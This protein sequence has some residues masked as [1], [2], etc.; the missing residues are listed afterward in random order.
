IDGRVVAR[1]G[2][3]VCTLDGGVEFTSAIKK[4]TLEQSGP[5]RATVK[6]EGVHK[7]TS[8]EWLPFVV[9]LYFYSGLENVRLVHTIV[10][11]GDHEKDFIRGLGVAFAV[12][13]R[14]QVHNRHVRFSGEGDG[15]WS[16]PVQPAIGRRPLSQSAFA[17]QL[18]G[19]RL[20]NKET[21][22][23]RGQKL[24]N[25]WAVWDD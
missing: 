19:K 23:P 16:E 1:D 14:E 22:D 7:N 3:L 15:L 4:V 20:P 12:P 24:L 2:R 10:F 9:R 5:V 11:D 21:Y 25:D 8:R 17:D 13:L 18:A 6:I